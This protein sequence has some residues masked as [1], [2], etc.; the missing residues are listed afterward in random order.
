MIALLPR[1]AH[2][3]SR[4]DIFEMLYALRQ[5]GLSYSEVARQDRYERRS[6]AKWLKFK[7]RQIGGE[8]H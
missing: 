6:V 8:Q 1:L 7:A 5:D 4:Q 3:Q 2:R